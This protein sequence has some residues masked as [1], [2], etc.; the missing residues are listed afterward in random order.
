MRLAT[1]NDLRCG[2]RL[3]DN[4]THARRT[5]FFELASKFALGTFNI[6]GMWPQMEQR[7]EVRRGQHAS[8]GFV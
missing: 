7:H 5:V 8:T 3:Y 1:D 4:A 6:T 2:L